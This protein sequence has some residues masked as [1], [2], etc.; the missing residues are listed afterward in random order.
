[1]GSLS[2]SSVP[3]HKFFRGVDL[4]LIETRILSTVVGRRDHGPENQCI[5]VLLQESDQYRPLPRPRPPPPRPGLK[6]DIV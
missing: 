3:L 5:W 2:P 1:M 6:L 4:I